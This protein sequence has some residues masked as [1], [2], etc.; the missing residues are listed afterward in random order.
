M[1]QALDGGGQMHAH[2]ETIDYKVDSDTVI[3][4][5]NAHVD[6]TGQG[7]FDGAHLVYNTKTGA[8]E[9]NGGDNGQVHL[10]LEPHKREA[11]AKPGNP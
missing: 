2:A 3:L 5:G 11:D 6:Q 9:G 10:I 7:S 1:Q 4:T 8:I